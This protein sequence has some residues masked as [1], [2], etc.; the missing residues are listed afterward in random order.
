MSISSNDSTTINSLTVFAG[1]TLQSSGSDT[2]PTEIPAGTTLSGITASGITQYVGGTAINTLVTGEHQLAFGNDDWYKI[3]GTQ[4]IQSGGEAFNTDLKSEFYTYY[5]FINPNEAL[6]FQ[7]VKNGGKV[8]NTTLTGDAITFTPGTG[9]QYFLETVSALQTVESGGLASGTHVQSGGVS[10][11]K[12]GGIAKDTTLS[13]TTEDFDLKSSFYENLTATPVHIQGAQFVTG[14]TLDVT[15][16]SDGLLDVTGVASH[17]VISSGGLLLAE[18]GSTLSDISVS[19]GGVIE[20]STGTTITDPISVQSGAAFIFAGIDNSNNTISAA[21]VSKSSETSGTAILDVL[22]AGSVLREV[23][24]Q[25]DFTSPL[26]FTRAASGNAF[27]MGF[28]TPCYCPGTLIATEEGEIPVENLQVG[29]RVQTASGE[30]RPIRWI[31]RR[32]YDPIFA[33]GNRD[34][35]PILL[36]K[37]SLGNTLPRRDLTVSPLHAMFVDGYLIPALHL[38]NGLSIIQIEKPDQIS[39]IHIELETHDIL[40]AEGAPSE[41]FIDDGSRG[42][43]HNAHEYSELYPD[44]PVVP[45]QY[46]APRLEDGEELARIY[47]RLKDYAQQALSEKAA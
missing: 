28:G 11:I 41:S 5:G 47:Q 10:I 23:Q 20:L 27:E 12:D 24:I 22:S 3:S 4:I 26:Y 39:Y 37:G 19:S 8:F 45:A 18:T 31:G 16:L 36:R 33:Y 34:V 46:C 42:M 29:T 15:I 9:A 30:I 17:V 13:G 6:S 43:F 40:L 25:G 1:G 44:A 32:A 21:I 2:N 35:L 38:V 7:I 14:T